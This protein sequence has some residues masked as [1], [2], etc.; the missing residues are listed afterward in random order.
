MATEYFNDAWRIPNNKN[1]SLVSNYS[2]ECDGTNDK[3]DFGDV[4]GFDITDKFSGSCWIYPTAAGNDY[5]LGKEQATSPYPGYMLYIGSDR[6]LRFI[7]AVQYVAGN[8]FGVLA[9]SS[10]IPSNTWTHLAFT[11]DGSTDRTGLKLYINSVLQTV[12]YTGSSTISGSMLN[13][14]VPFQISG[15]GGSSANGISGKIDQTC[16]F[17]Y[18]LSASQVSTLYGGGTAVTNPMALSPKPIAAY[19][20]G[21]QSVDNGANYLVPN[22]SL[23]DYVFNFDSNNANQITLNNGGGNG[24]LNAATSFTISAWINP[25]QPTANATIFAHWGGGILIRYASN[26]TCQMFVTKADGGVTLINSLA[27]KITFNGDWQNFVATYDGSEI[28]M[29]INNALIRTPTAFTSA[30]FDDTTST[31]DIIGGRGTEY[32]NGKM[33]NVAIW[34]NS[35]INVTTLYNNGTPATD[36]SSLNPTAWYKLN[37]QDTFDG[38]NWTIKDYAG[39][40]DGTSNGMTSANLIQSNLQ[41]TSGFSPYALSLDGTNQFLEVPFSNNLRLTNIDFTISFWTNPSATGRYIMLENY[42]PTVGWGVFNDNGILEFLQ[43]SGTWLVTSVTIPNNVWT[44]IVLVGDISATNLQVY[45]N[46]VSAG[47]FNTN[48]VTGNATGPLTIGAQRNGAG[49]FDYNG[50][51]SNLSIWS[52]TALSSIEVTEVYNQGVPSN[53]NTFSGTKPTAWWQLGTNSSFNAN[54][55]QLTCLDEIGT[56]NAVS[57]TNMAEDDVTNGPGYSANGLGT[58]SIEI[59]GDA[60]YSTLNGLSENMDVLDRTTDVPS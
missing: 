35:V 44:H 7:M 8:Y 41:H 17:D 31:Q 21:D 2:M 30:L 33:S 40:N 57:S 60:P 10:T 27:F 39:S 49:G 58:S 25:T 55:S 51:L 54:T 20:L 59:I 46:G 22:N 34:K 6:K 42:S 23:Q 1:Q 19:Q 16:I 32:F 56:L 45:K 12:S 28:K 14:T 15:R 43:D 47:N 11:Y 26:G 5:I 53:L 9:N 4:N 18:E 50:D 24:L 37:A 52:G 36:I 29:Y 48:L 38:T 13:S 3:I